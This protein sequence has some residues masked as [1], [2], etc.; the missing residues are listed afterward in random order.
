MNVLLKYTIVLNYSLWKMLRSSFYDILIN[1]A[2]ICRWEKWLKGKEINEVGEGASCVITCME[3]QFLEK[4]FL[5]FLSV[6]SVV[7]Y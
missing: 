5:F 4:H 3:D 1:I 6:S 7:K 2:M